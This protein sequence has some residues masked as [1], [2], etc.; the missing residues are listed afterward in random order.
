MK[1]NQK[2]VLVVSAESKPYD[3]NG[4][5]G[6]SHKVQVLCDGTVW[7]LKST[8]DQVKRLQKHVEKRVGVDIEFKCTNG[9]IYAQLLD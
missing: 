5:T 8:E 1:I 7:P 9:R 4:N 3:V 6:V 2:E